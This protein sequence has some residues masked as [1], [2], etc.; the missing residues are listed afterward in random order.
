MIHTTLHDMYTDTYKISQPLLPF[1][2][3]PT[4]THQHTPHT[5]HTHTNTHTHPQP[6]VTPVCMAGIRHARVVCHS[7]AQT[8]NS[9]GFR[10]RSLL[11]R[12]GMSG[13]PWWV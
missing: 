7:V 13:C 10:P 5:P 1:L 12:E 2:H 9:A 8:K 11:I 4:E 3:R 6:A